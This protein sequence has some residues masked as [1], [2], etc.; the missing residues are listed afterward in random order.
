MTEKAFGKQNVISGDYRIVEAR[1][2][3]NPTPETAEW[4]VYFKQA[5]DPISVHKTRKEALKAVARYQDADKR[6]ELQR[7]MR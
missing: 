3:Y 5:L 6:R 1:S 7:A 2:T 4:R